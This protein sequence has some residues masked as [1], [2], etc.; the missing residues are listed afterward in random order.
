MQTEIIKALMGAAGGG[1]KVYVDDVFNPFLYAGTDGALTGNSGLDLSGE[2][3]MIWIKNRTDSGRNHQ[4]FDTE[5]GVN[6]TIAITTGAEA[7]NSNFNQTFTSTGFTLNNDYANYNQSTK[8]YCAWN[9]RKAKG[10]FDVVTYTGNGSSSGQEVAHSL[11]SVPGCVII[12]CLQSNDAHAKANNWI[13][14]HRSLTDQ[15]FLYWNVNENEDGAG[16]FQKSDVTSTYVRVPKSG[17][18]TA[19]TDTMNRN[20]YSYVM[21]LFA[22]DEQSFGEGGDQ[23]IIK[24]GNFTGNGNSGDNG[25]FVTLGW[26][27]QFVMV[28][29][30]GNDA[31]WNVFDSMRGIVDG[32]NDNKLKTENA[33]LESTN[34]DWLDVR[35]T[36]FRVRNAGN[37]MN[38]NGE[39]IVYVAIRRPDGYVGKPAEAGT[40]VF[41]MDTGAGT[42]TMPNIDSGFP[43]DWALLKKT[44][45]DQNWFASARLLQ[46]NYLS[47]NT[48]SAKAGSSAYVF[49]SNVGWNTGGSNID[50][51]YQSWMWKR[52]AGFDMVCWAADQQVRQISHRLSKTP[53][54]IW[55]KSYDTGFNWKVYHKGANG[56]TT[57][58]QYYFRLNHNDAE[59]T[60]SGMWNNTA[61][62]STVFTIGTAG[63]V[64]NSGSRYIAML[65]ASVEGIS[66]VGYFNGSSSAQTITTGFQPRFVIIKSTTAAYPWVVLDTT[67][68]WASGN[69]Q[70][71]QLNDSSEQLAFDQ[72]A[73][74]STGFTVPVGSGQST[75]VNEANEKY[76]YYAHA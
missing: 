75:Y 53:E 4:I 7:T 65:F 58:E 3:G 9:F 13:F 29:S 37:E 23:S 57:P 61:P 2:G 28:K 69:D 17:G 27:P 63:G 19:Q 46:K 44:A 42:E 68:G 38:G 6:K 16:W 56:G 60:D 62:T 32:G 67:R 25:P 71:L 73:P 12:K 45:V 48:S 20:G 55:V 51:A 35:A 49:D 50:S 10:F 36:G 34:Q 1:D 14:Y 40:D 8:N 41:A 74:T 54:M 5:R 64:N 66:K 52:H 59:N 30:A 11:G 33:N 26:E 70:W 21:Y 31:D 18:N 24:C 72:G 47:P 76:I 43:V 22:H 39:N 15:H